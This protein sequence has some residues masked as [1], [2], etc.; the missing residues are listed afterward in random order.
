MFQLYNLSQGIQKVC[1]KMFPVRFSLEDAKSAE[2]RVLRGI[3]TGENNAQSKDG[4][5][6]QRM[7]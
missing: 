2:T 1:R 3:E 4:S 7:L 6:I 5:L